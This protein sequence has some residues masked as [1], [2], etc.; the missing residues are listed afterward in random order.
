VL[1]FA[2]YHFHY[3]L[4]ELYLSRGGTPIPLKQE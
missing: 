4:Y 1:M 3:Q 2:Q